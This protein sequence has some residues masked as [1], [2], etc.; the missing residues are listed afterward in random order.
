MRRALLAAG[1]GLAGALLTLACTDT[2]APVERFRASIVNISAPDSLAPSDTADVSFDYEDS[3][4]PREVLYTFAYNRLTVSVV[5]TL[6]ANA[7]CPAVLRYT[8]RS[9]A[10]APNE[11]AGSYTITFLQPSGADSVRVIHP[12]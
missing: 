3:C 2:T 4:G 12:R 1:L 6:P 9:I 7:V 10:I 11:R 8:R 5:G